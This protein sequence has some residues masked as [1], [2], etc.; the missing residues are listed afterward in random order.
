VLT[1]DARYAFSGF[2]GLA[3]PPAFNTVKS[4]KVVELRFSLEGAGGPNPLAGT[5][6]SQVVSCSTGAAVGPEEPLVG[7]L[8]REGDLYVFT[9]ETPKRDKR[10]C[11]VV[12]VR[13][14]DGTEHRVRFYLR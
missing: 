11:R 3:A 5:P 8:R 12:V 10:E 9:W 7:D 4:G 13:L 1:L 6:V 2:D 14:D